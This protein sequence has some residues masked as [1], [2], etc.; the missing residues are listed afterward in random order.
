MFLSSDSS[1]HFQQ[2]AL[3]CASKSV[4]HKSYLYSDVQLI[5]RLSCPVSTSVLSYQ[6]KRYTSEVLSDFG[7]VMG[8]IINGL[9]TVR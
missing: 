6:Q 9:S 7:Q 4:G 8:C 5:F 2:T 1:V 3:S